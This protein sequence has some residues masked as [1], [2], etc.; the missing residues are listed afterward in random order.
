MQK[1]SIQSKFFESLVVDFRVLLYF[2]YSFSQTLK[3]NKNLIKSSENIYFS[4]TES[5][6]IVLRG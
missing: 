3:I 2:S 6:G 4:Y 1:S 5:D